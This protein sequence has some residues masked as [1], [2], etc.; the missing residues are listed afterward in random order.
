MSST[1]PNNES[2]ESR[3]ESTE[4]E[5][6]EEADRTSAMR[7]LQISRRETL[8]GITTAASIG[9]VGAA[10]AADVSIL[11]ASQTS[12]GVGGSV[13]VLDIDLESDDQ[14]IDV[15][16]G[17]AL[18]ED[19]D[20]V[21]EDYDAVVNDKHP[22]PSPT[23]EVTPGDPI[24]NFAIDDR[25]WTTAFSD[26]DLETDALWQSPTNRPLVA[27][28]ERSIP[29]FSDNYLP[30][31][32]AA[33]FS[34]FLFDEF[35]DEDLE[36][37]DFRVDRVE[38]TEF[39]IPTDADS[40]E[41]G[42]APQACPSFDACNQEKDTL[43]EF[44][45]ALSTDLSSV[46][47]PQLAV[48]VDSI[49]IGQEGGSQD[50][51]LPY[52]AQ[53]AFNDGILPNNGTP[54]VTPSDE[55]VLV[56]ENGNVPD[57]HSD[58]A[59]G[60]QVSYAGNTVEIEFF[61]HREDATLPNAGF[62]TEV[63]TDSCPGEP[64]E[65]G[66]P[67]ES[68]NAP[69]EITPSDETSGLTHASGIGLSED[70]FD[71]QLQP[72]V[73]A[74]LEDGTPLI[75]DRQRNDE[76]ELN[77]ATGFLDVVSNETVP[78]SELAGSEIE[79]QRIERTNPALDVSRN[80]GGDVYP[81][82]S[83]ANGYIQ[84]PVNPG[85][86]TQNTF[87][88]NDALLVQKVNQDT[89]DDV[90]HAVL[91]KGGLDSSAR[92]DETAQDTEWDPRYGD[93]D[94][95]KCIPE[96]LID[97][98]YEGA[99][100]ASNALRKLDWEPDDESVKIKV[101]G[102]EEDPEGTPLVLAGGSDGDPSSRAHVLL[103]APFDGRNDGTA[104]GSEL[105]DFVDTNDTLGSQNDA[106]DVDDVEGELEITRDP[107]V[108]YSLSGTDGN[109]LDGTSIKF[110][111][112]GTPYIDPDADDTGITAEVTATWGVVGDG[113][114]NRAVTPGCPDACRTESVSTEVE[115]ANEAVW[116]PVD[117]SLLI[118]QPPGI[119]VTGGSGVF[120]ADNRIPVGEEVKLLAT[121]EFTDGTN[122]R[123]VDIT[124]YDETPVSY[125]SD[126]TTIAQVGSTGLIDVQHTDQDR[127]ATITVDAGGLGTNEVEGETAAYYYLEGVAATNSTVYSDDR[128]VIRL[129][130]DSDG[131]PA[132][133]GN[134]NTAT[135]DERVL[136]TGEKIAESLEQGINT[137]IADQRHEPT[138]SVFFDPDFHPADGYVV[139]SDTLVNSSFHQN[140][141]HS[142][143]EIGAFEALVGE[144][145]IEDDFDEGVG[146]EDL[147]S[148]ERQNVA[149]ALGFCNE[150]D[151]EGNYVEWNSLLASVL[152][153]SEERYSTSGI[154]G[155]Q[156]RADPLNEASYAEA[157]GLE[158]GSGCFSR[159]FL[160]DNELTC[161]LD[162]PE[163]LGLTAEGLL[164]T[165]TLEVGTEESVITYY[166]TPNLEED[167]DIPENVKSNPCLARETEGNERF[168]YAGE[169]EGEEQL[170]PFIEG[171]DIVEIRDSI[172]NNRDDADDPS[173]A[174]DTLVR[175]EEPAG[176]DDGDGRNLSDDETMAHL[177]YG[178]RFDGL[179]V[180]NDGSANMQDHV[181]EHELH[182]LNDGDRDWITAAQAIDIAGED[183]S[184]LFPQSRPDLAV[185][186]GTSTANCELDDY[187]YFG[188]DQE[189]ELW[190]G[191]SGETTCST[192]V[193]DNVILGVTAELSAEA[194]SGRTLKYE[195]PKL[196][197]EDKDGNYD[198]VRPGADDSEVSASFQD[199]GI[200]FESHDDQGHPDPVLI[201]DTITIEGSGSGGGGGGGGSTPTSTPTPTPTPGGGGGSTPT[202][203][204]GGGS[205]SPCDNYDC[206]NGNVTTTGL[207]DAVGDW[208][209]G[210]LDTTDLI[211]VINSWRNR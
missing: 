108:E 113:D 204:G 34:L 63:E 180:R 18:D 162:V 78:G 163:D 56:D 103:T 198:A 178:D 210:N 171:Y 61:D 165:E 77:G 121:A 60:Y 186:Y 54:G 153:N 82:L 23:Q 46:I 188:D 127:T 49:G 120:E 35:A 203:G 95:E 157:A 205:F 174:P 20:G 90:L 196:Y 50:I 193:E 200:F 119:D 69:D 145:I 45:Y 33:S 28:G 107:R 41:N 148:L 17:S 194:E 139:A 168:R 112:N 179:S 172:F 116:D 72:G 135:V 189:H 192:P 109:E 158:G 101:G 16:G 31:G 104:R 181:R 146:V 86:F 29:L 62:I 111:E 187:D 94:D 149:C 3:A 24:T 43:V 22:T 115:I 131:S 138:V 2:S 81:V 130:T 134:Q 74:E 59:N 53:E 142:S 155:Y 114:Y 177:V 159:E 6:K 32:H 190:F 183:R 7:D 209:D 65:D 40:E 136:D 161:N 9:G 64:F 98:Q 21:V 137:A 156:A 83:A 97:N 166:P 195:V 169:V 57:L 141:D 89:G 55:A 44:R 71:S 132:T 68:D 38:S 176:V 129:A 133:F 175:E 79:Q 52:T 128:D 144:K 75:T 173:D 118:D 206:D 48:K 19:D 84:I 152:D 25:V 147:A 73:I 96:G 99:I 67:Y 123:R 27:E 110:T 58:D 140:V 92:V 105:V 182:V 5:K 143:V 122:T 164:G 37:G 1:N 199:R 13:R 102:Q 10:T 125:S 126:D 185:F 76:P 208:R 39:G 150:Y 160:G 87:E 91:P 151:G 191:T 85:G 36:Q 30:L 11:D 211:D 42:M 4:P 201:G 66:E 51:G 70:D 170:Y 184:P 12:V 80:A 202:P 207:V 117:D 88:R 197:D 154:H 26:F 167:E 8:A 106:T 14:V 124:D 100:S 15:S 93:V 47:N